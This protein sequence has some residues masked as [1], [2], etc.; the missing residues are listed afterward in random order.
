MSRCVGV[1]TAK[2]IETVA[3]VGSPFISRTDLTDLSGRT[4]TA[5]PG[6]TIAIDSACAMVRTFTEQDLDQ[7]FNERITLDGT[8]TDAIVLPQLPVTNLGTVNLISS[9]GGTT[10]V[11]DYALN[12]HGVLLRKRGSA[13]YSWPTTIAWPVGRQNVQINY[14][15]GYAEVPED[16]RMVALTLAKRIL[17]QGEAIQEGVGQVNVRYGINATDLTDGE[18]AILAKYRQLG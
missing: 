2:R 11:T 14:D 1:A 4:V 7:V 3:S 18:K 8:G 5:D 6:A 16:I 10:A 12:G 13:N 9:S 15:H 17:I